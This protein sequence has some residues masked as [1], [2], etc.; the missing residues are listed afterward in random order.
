MHINI[1]TALLEARSFVLSG[2][3]SKRL[4]ARLAGVD[5]RTLRHAALSSWDPRVSTLAGILDAMAQLDHASDNTTSDV[6]PQLTKKA[7]VVSPSACIK[8]TNS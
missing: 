2:L 5:D 7:N 8:A 4:I 6:S 3:H 1:R